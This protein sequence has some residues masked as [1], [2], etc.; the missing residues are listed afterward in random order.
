[1]LRPFL[2]SVRTTCV[3]TTIRKC[4]GKKYQQ[5]YCVLRE[6]F[7]SPEVHDHTPLA[8]VQKLEERKTMVFA[9]F[10]TRIASDKTASI[11]VAACESDALSEAEKETIRSRYLQTVRTPRRGA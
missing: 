9:Q 8:D 4:E 5:G 11:V 2:V 3:R 7:Y 6:V 10:S 1:M